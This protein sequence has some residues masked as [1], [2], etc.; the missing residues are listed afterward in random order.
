MILDGEKPKKVEKILLTGSEISSF[1]LY[2][3]YND[4]ESNHDTL[5][6]FKID[7]SIRLFGLEPP[8]DFINTKYGNLNFKLKK[9]KDFIIYEL[10]DQYIIESSVNASDSI[11]SLIYKNKK[12]FLVE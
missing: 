6:E 12:Y 10:E 9:N 4:I 11:P 7:N 3:S 1:N 5:S 8:Y 2:R